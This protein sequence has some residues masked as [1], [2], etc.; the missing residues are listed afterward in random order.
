MYPAGTLVRV[1]KSD[2]HAKASPRVNSIGYVASSEELQYL[3]LQPKKNMIGKTRTPQL[4]GAEL[5]DIVFVRF[6]N[7]IHDRHERH[8]V[9]VFKPNL[10][11]SF[12]ERPQHADAVNRLINRNLTADEEEI[13]RERLGVGYKMPWVFI[14]RYEGATRINQLADSLISNY[15]FADFVRNVNSLNKNAYLDKVKNPITKL[16]SLMDVIQVADATI[17]Y[18]KGFCRNLSDNLKK[19]FETMHIMFKSVELGALAD[20]VVGYVTN[21]LRCYNHNNAGAITLRRDLECILED[22]FYNTNNKL[23]AKHLDNLIGAN[24]PFKLEKKMKELTDGFENYKKA[25]AI[26]G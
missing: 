3:R 15:K 16:L 22:L 18:N 5:V 11:C 13:I 6:G 20:E 21:G 12:I 25:L 23:V 2:R 9:V 4:I 19:T 24:Y 7:Q 8:N 26:A 10:F 17:D 1:I 14:D